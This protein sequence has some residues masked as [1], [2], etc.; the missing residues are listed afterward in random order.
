MISRWSLDAHVIQKA[1]VATWLAPWRRDVAMCRV[2]NCRPGFPEVSCVRGTAD[3]LLRV[4]LKAEERRSEVPE[5][6]CASCASCASGASWSIERRVHVI[7]CC[8]CR[9]NLRLQAMQATTR[10]KMAE[11]C[12]ANPCIPEESHNLS[13]NYHKVLKYVEIIIDCFDL[14]RV[15]LPRASKPSG[16]KYS[17][18]QG[19]HCS[20]GGWDA[21]DGGVW[22]A[23]AKE[24]PGMKAKDQSWNMLKHVETDE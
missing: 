3:F 18:H 12:N 8:M 5:I 17:V 22:R 24:K 20:G 15:F 19:D 9:W 2:R 14:L 13:R 7:P 23:Y 4:Y 10:L 11:R 16:S 1:A 21:V 6:S